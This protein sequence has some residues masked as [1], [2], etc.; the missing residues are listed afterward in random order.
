MHND[1]NKHEDENNLVS[2]LW[3]VSA[4]HFGVLES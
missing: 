1:D 2:C 4:L 3:M